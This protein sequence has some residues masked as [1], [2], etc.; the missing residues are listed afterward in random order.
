MI[1]GDV[2]DDATWAGI[3]ADSVHCCL[4]S[5]PYW[6]LRDYG[7]SSWQG[8]EEGCDHKAPDEAGKTDKP[9]AGQREHA[10][11]F[12][13]KTC[14]K[15]GAL[16]IDTQVGLEKD[17]R[18]YIAK[19]VQVCRQVRRVLREDAV[20]FLNVG[21]SYARAGG[22]S[23]NNGLDGVSR[24]ECKRPVSKLLSSQS[25]A[26][27]LKPKDLC[28]I[29]QRLAIA[30]QEDGWWVRSMMPWCKRNSMPESCT[31]RPA[32]A[33][34]YVLMLVKSPRYFFDMEAVKQTGEG[35][36]RGTGECAFRSKRYQNNASFDNAAATE[37]SGA[38]GHSFE[39]GRNFRNADL[40]FESIEKPHG[41]IFVVDEPVGIDRTTQGYKGAHY[42]V[43][44]IKFAETL[45]KA[46]TSAKG[47][48]PECGKPWARVVKK[49]RKATRPGKDTK[50]TGDSMTDGNRDPERHVTDTQTLG[51]RPQ[52]S[53]GGD[54]VPCLVFDPFM[55]AG[56]VGVVAQRLGL[57]WQGIELNPKYADM[58]ER[59]IRAEAPLLAKEAT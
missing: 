10:G 21:D 55:G 1:V 33:L 34:E 7:T 51:W 47:C 52:C 57:R 19:I 59:R 23:N 49:D 14:W 41:M 54:P 27:G 58:A 30:L 16:R 20:F 25:L 13:G 42:A 36:G 45:L 15:C 24:A 38:H 56:T 11:R 18:E 8:G 31:D 32:S 26:D 12:A 44:P 17:F 29:P 9:T 48:C 40:F 43:F 37:K 35:Y 4:T 3:E 22:W 2:M 39:G 5:P 28:L 50:V 53:C 6:G 46:G